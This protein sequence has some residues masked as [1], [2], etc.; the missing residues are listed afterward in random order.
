MNKKE[1]GHYVRSWSQVLLDN[2][3][4]SGVY[5]DWHDSEIYT[6]FADMTIEEIAEDVIRTEASCLKIMTDDLVEAYKDEL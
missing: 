2:G 6:E 5:I 1:L 3:K 4:G